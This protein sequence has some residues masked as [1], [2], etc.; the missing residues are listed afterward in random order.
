MSAL[1]I[2]HIE[3]Q[4]SDRHATFRRE[5][6]IDGRQANESV[7]TPLGESAV[8]IAVRSITMLCKYLAST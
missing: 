2:M 8:C 7:G 5:T 6:I 3:Y 1:P 4:C